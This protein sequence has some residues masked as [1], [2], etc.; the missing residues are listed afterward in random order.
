MRCSWDVV[1]TRD[2]HEHYVNYYG[3]VRWEVT[4]PRDPES[5]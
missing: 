2:Y 1:I 4:K 3:L 5:V